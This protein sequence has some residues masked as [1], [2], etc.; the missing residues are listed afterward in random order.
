MLDAPELADDFYLN[1]VDRSSTK[2]IG[3]IGR[4]SGQRTIQLCPSYARQFERYCQLGVV[5]TKGVS[6][7]FSLVSPFLTSLLSF[8]G[9]NARGWEALGL[10]AYL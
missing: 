1:P 4:I 3:R 5:G 6:D 10:H 8:T 2:C 9:N 7:Y